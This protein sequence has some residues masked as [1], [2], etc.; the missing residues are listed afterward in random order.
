MVV[1]QFIAHYELIEAVGRGGMGVVYKARDTSLNRFVALKVLRK[2][3]SQHAEFI[4]QLETEAAIT[5]SINHPHVVRVFT[6]GTDAGR[7]YIAMELVDKGTLD[8][9][10]GLQ[11][12]VAEAQVLEIAI[13]IAQ[14]LRA[15]YQHGLIHRDVKPGNILFADAHTAK[16]VDF[17]LAMLEAAAQGGGE[18]WGTPYY[19][20]PEKL[21]RKPEDFRSD[22]YSLGATL[23][24]AL[25]GRPP[26]EADDASMV[27]L[28]HLKSQSVSLQAFAPHISSSTAYVINRTLLKDPDKRYQ[29]YDEFIEH[30]S[31]AKG[32]LEKKGTQPLP[33]QRVVLETAAHQKMMSYLTFAM[34]GLALILGAIGWWYF[35]TEVKVKSTNEQEPVAKVSATPTPPPS[36]VLAGV[37]PRTAADYQGA[38]KLLLDGKPEDAA[39]VFKTIA[40]DRKI[41]S[42]LAEWSIIQLGLA[43]LVA[44]REV[45]SR[46]AFYSILNRKMDDAS[47]KENNLGETLRELSQLASKDTPAPAAAVQRFADAKGGAIAYLI[48]GLKNWRAGE[49]DSAGEMLSRFG[50]SDFTGFE[51]MADYRKL[52]EEQ[53]AEYRDYRQLAAMAEMAKDKKG[54]DDALKALEK[55]REAF[56]TKQLAEKLEV[57]AKDLQS[58][59][60]ARGRETAKRKED[61]IAAMT[62]IRN[63]V[64]DASRAW[65]FVEAR[66]AAEKAAFLTDEKRR[67]RAAML[68]QLDLLQR[69]KAA[70]LTELNANLAKAALK[71]KDG[72]EIKNLIKVTN[73]GVEAKGTPAVNWP[74][75][76]PESVIA[77]TANLVRQD[78][79]PEL[80]A[81]RRWLLGTFASMV[82]VK[83]ADQ[84]LLEAAK[85]KPAYV[86][87]LPLV[88][89]AFRASGENLARGKTATA[90]DFV[91]TE[92]FDES[93]GKALDSDPK[94]KWCGKETGPKWLA[95]DL[96]QPLNITRWVVQ[97]ASCGGET[98]DMN[99]AD[100]ELQ[101]S[102]DGKT[103]T[104]VDK[105]TGNRA[106][107]TARSVAMFTARQVRLSITK[108]NHRANDPTARIVDFAVQGPSKIKGG[109]DTVKN[110][111]ES[112]GWLPAPS[113]TSVNIGKVGQRGTTHLSDRAGELSIRASGDDVWKT[114]DAFRFT[115]QKLKGDGEIIARVSSVEQSHEWT[116]AGLMF[117]ENLKPESPNVLL[118]LTP[119]P[120]LTLQTRPTA[121]VETTSQQG[122]AERGAPLWLKLVREGA[123][124]TGFTSTDGIT[125][126]EYKST[127]AEMPPEIHVGLALASHVN[128][129]LAL[130]KFDFVQITGKP[131]EKPAVPKLTPPAP[132]TAPRPPTPP[133]AP[134]RRP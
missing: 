99:T 11:G 106:D 4:S 38:R 18:V 96:G 8:D 121:S 74:D 83:G 118:A 97:H 55:A 25:A 73:N 71:K 104:T 128:N 23:F 24:H 36:P 40:S 125:W 28:K 21:D 75:I 3:H 93:P 51:W 91:K 80:L 105:V 115:H 70:T 85:A 26:Y 123:K 47:L 59:A 46:K 87:E 116:K 30:L 52:S 102:D 88:S 33:K 84:L 56:H 66:Q 82:G 48:L 32:E 131:V 6:T 103:W 10:I 19:V 68:L 89:P 117:R 39:A 53:I 60:E 119:F 76:V 2:D 54:E 45:E 112:N 92:E 114:A 41:P 90:S 57:I 134:S 17:G 111:F 81:E 94:T 100:Y 43:E 78:L 133:L 126:K 77:A 37:D 27:A 20:A 61:D 13:Q 9:L 22:I 110:F 58:K 12:Q 16:I 49:Y 64:V 62:L 29:S 34:L 132:P 95:V 15:A 113:F 67:E 108:P 7:F 107:F 44:G 31:Y 65:K 98:D 79:P 127:T 63:E 69:W 1:G 120:R 50:T 129:T 42:P 86:N 5:A 101:W 72:T 130:A 124:F 35:A 122:D 109:D 14:G